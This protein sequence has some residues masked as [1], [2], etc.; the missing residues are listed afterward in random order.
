MR[1]SNFIFSLASFIAVSVGLANRLGLVSGTFGLNEAFLI[2]GF[3]AS[4]I[5]SC[6]CYK[7]GYTLA[8]MDIK[9]RFSGLAL[10]LW[11]LLVFDLVF[12]F[13]VFFVEYSNNFGSFVTLFLL[14]PIVILLY[15]KGRQIVASNET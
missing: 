14:S 9:G 15:K 4:V 7:V 8:A 2:S 5:A 3:S 10:F 1:I 11:L 6:I 13:N 12:G